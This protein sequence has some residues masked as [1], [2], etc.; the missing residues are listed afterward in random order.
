MQ[1]IAPLP[2]A[3]RWFARFRLTGASGKGPFRRGLPRRRILR[4]PLDRGA[5]IRCVRGRL[6]V[7][8]DSLQDDIVV[9]AGESL[10]V[11]RQGLAVI[12]ALESSIVEIS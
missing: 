11:A 7:T 8:L 6:W 9:S 4:Q 12:E 5:S 10:E 1:T 2:L 3:S